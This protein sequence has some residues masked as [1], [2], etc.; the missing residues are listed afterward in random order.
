[1]VHQL[2]S[3]CLDFLCVEFLEVSLRGFSDVLLEDH[4]LVPPSEE[5]SGVLG[6]R[7]GILPLKILLLHTILFVSDS[8]SHRASISNISEL[9]GLVVLVILGLCHGIEYDLRNTFTIT[10]IW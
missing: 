9:G 7:S 8:S 10:R 1:M 5:A 6:L 4:V 2:D 3:V